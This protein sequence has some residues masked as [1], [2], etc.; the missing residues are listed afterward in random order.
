MLAR[1]GRVRVPSRFVVLGVAF[2]PFVG[3]VLM[4]VFVTRVALSLRRVA[5]LVGAVVLRL[6]VA[7]AAGCFV[8][9]REIVHG[10]TP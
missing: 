10:S 1:V 3:F 4:G 5:A 7:F 9:L 2:R 6:L 8:V